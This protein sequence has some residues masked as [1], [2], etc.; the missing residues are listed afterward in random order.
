MANLIHVASVAEFIELCLSHGYTTREHLGQYEQAV[1]L[2]QNSRTVVVYQAAKKM[3]LYCSVINC[4]A[5][6]SHLVS[7]A[8]QTATLPTEPAFDQGKFEQAIVNMKE[9]PWFRIFKRPAY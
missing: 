1:L 7:G 2:S 6:A 3:P 8:A 5:F 4:P 9:S